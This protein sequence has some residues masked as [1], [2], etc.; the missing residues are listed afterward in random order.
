MR[1]SLGVL[2]SGD[3]V[4]VE[5][6]EMLGVRAFVVDGVGTRSARL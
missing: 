2:S 4:E 6:E 5:V 1:W 3:G